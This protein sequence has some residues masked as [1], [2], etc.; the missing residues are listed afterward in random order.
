MDEETDSRASTP[1]EVDG[2]S[3]SEVDF[4]SRLRSG[5]AAD[6][7]YRYDSTSL[8]LIGVLFKFLK[9]SFRVELI[10]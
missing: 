6:E 7:T 9:R 3:S 10:K 1:V 4:P 2:D 5:S 8:A